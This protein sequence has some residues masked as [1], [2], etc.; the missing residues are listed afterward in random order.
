MEWIINYDSVEI[1]YGGI[2]KT[3]GKTRVATVPVGYA[4]GYPR[5]LSNKGYVL[6][7]GKKARIL[8]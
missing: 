3:S 6:V 5:S 8:G 2:Y 1:S 7:R 4:D